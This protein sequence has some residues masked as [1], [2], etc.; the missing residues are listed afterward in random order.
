MQ[1]IIIELYHLI[2][3][4]KI[5]TLKV[6]FLSLSVKRPTTCQH[7]NLQVGQCFATGL[8]F[9]LGIQVSSTNKTDHHDITEIL[10][11]QYFFLY[12]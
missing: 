6:F 12:F 7:Q 8:W 1:N 10:S 9:S 4:K 5:L 11:T 3:H 2:L